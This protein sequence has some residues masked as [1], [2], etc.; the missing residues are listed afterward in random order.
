MA[1]SQKPPSFD[2]Q[3]LAV[4][5]L[6]AARRLLGQSLCVLDARGEPTRGRIVEVEAYRQSDPAC[7]AYR[8]RTRRNQSLFLSAGHA[9]VYR[10][11]GIHW[12]VNVTCEGEGE[13]AAVL[14]RALAPEAG[15]A[16]M[17]LRRGPKVSAESALC[18]GP[19]NVCRA[20]GIDERHDGADL[21]RPTGEVALC[22]GPRVDREQIRC[23]PRIGIRRATE[24]AWRLWLVDAPAVSGSRTRGRPLTASRSP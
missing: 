20:L 3:C 5:A 16:H 21:C 9:Y 8:G 10:S 4:H 2:R 18:R 11:Y 24:R 17:R 13:G 22:P 19:G 15:V 23:G 7:H 1:R 12:C 14:I 6:T